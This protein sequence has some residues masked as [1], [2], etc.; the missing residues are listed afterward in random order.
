M[1]AASRASA[2]TA[3]TSSDARA[4]IE[5]QR[6]HRA[7]VVRGG[8]GGPLH[9]FLHFGGQ[10]V[11]AADISDAHIV[12]VHALDVVDQVGAQQTHEE[13]DFGLGTAQIV[14]EREG[15]ER[16]PRQ[17]DARGRLDHVLD[18]LGALLMPEKAPEAALACPASVAVH[19]DGYVL[20][21][22]SRIQLAVDGLLFGR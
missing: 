10:L 20:R 13:V 3:S 16:Q 7:V 22:A 15:V 1:E 6:Q 12:V 19:D 11:G 17:V 4:V 9:L 8:F 18:R 2:L 5:R 21:Q 14:L